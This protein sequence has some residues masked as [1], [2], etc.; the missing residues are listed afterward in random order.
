MCPI[1]VISMNVVSNIYYLSNHL[2]SNMIFYLYFHVYLCRHGTLQEFQIRN[3]FFYTQ[4]SLCKYEVIVLVESRKT[5]RSDK[6]S[7]EIE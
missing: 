1:R 3:F 4:S 5:L 7:Y 6:L 2:Y